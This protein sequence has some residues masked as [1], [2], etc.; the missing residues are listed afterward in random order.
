MSIQGMKNL[1][2]E[3]PT[4]RFVLII[5]LNAT[6]RAVDRI[7]FE[8]LPDAD[9][10]ISKFTVSLETDGISKEMVDPPREQWQ[11]VISWQDTI[12]RLK[13]IADIVDY[14]PR[15]SS[16]GHIELRLSKNRFAEFQLTTN[17]DPYSDDRVT[18]INEGTR[19]TPVNKITP[20]QQLEFEREMGQFFA[21]I[22]KDAVVVEAPILIAISDT[23]EI[24][25]EK[26]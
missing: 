18:L 3:S 25:G 23:D 15:K 14:G 16:E 22:P 13:V 10:E 20:E 6:K 9:S 8:K 17:P 11:D 4:A 5:L 21:D 24:W 2:N 1:D 26:C 7:H 19:E 12:R